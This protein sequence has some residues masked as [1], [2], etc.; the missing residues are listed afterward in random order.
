L[1][2][3]MIQDAEGAVGRRAGALYLA[4]TAGGVLG[5]LAGGFLLL[6]A[7]GIQRSITWLAVVALLGAAAVYAAAHEV[8][9]SGTPRRWAAATL[10]ASLVIVMGSLVPWLG[11]PPGYLVSRAIPPLQRQTDRV[12]VIT[13]GVHGI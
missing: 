7:L 5:S 1:A 9:P 3:A 6:P 4:N 12:L 13:E 8:L 2:N 10:A 11:L